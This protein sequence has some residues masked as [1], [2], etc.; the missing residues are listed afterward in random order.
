M[1]LKI[2]D[3]L[4]GIATGIILWFAFSILNWI[5]KGLELL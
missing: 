4:W 5:I 2:T 3:L 1:K